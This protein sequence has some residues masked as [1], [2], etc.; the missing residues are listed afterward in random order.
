M[1]M[2]NMTKKRL[3]QNLWSIFI[4]NNKYKCFLDSEKKMFNTSGQ[5]GG[6]G[7]SCQRSGGTEAYG[8]LNGPW[9]AGT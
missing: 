5:A 8:G 1:N 2:I 7:K 3:I 6:R 4:V 9:Q